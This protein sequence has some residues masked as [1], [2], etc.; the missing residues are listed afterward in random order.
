MTW[1]SFLMIVCL[2]VNANFVFMCNTLLLQRVGE[3][4]F[5]CQKNGGYEAAIRH[6][7]LAVQIIFPLLNSLV[8]GGTC[9]I[10]KHKC[11]NCISVINL[12]NGSH[13][14]KIKTMS[15]II[16]GRTLNHALIHLTPEL[17][18]KIHLFIYI[19]I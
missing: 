10:K 13:R 3:S 19:Y 11:S 16:H 8:R 6:K 2:I 15:L 7:C 17:T 12:R 9:H 14:E 18:K 4:H 5:V 1:S